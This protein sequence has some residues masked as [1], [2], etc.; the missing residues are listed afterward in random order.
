M[1]HTYR[2][3]GSLHF[4]DNVLIKNILTNGWLVCN[5]G[6]RIT[7]DEEAY[8]V[9]TTSQNIGPSARSILSI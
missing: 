7:S 6:D 5:T 8:A 3:D 2:A 4:G 1:P 9:T